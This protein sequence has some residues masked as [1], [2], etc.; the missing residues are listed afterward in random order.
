MPKPP[1]SEHNSSTAIANNMDDE[2]KPEP[3]VPSQAQQSWGTLVAIVVI[4][5]MVV[6]GAFYAWGKR[7]AQDRD[8]T[9]PVTT[10]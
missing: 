10:Q 9:T 6:V 1:S 2:K 4:V 7:I 3:G 5:G 8:L